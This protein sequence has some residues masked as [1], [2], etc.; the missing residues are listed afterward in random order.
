MRYVLKLVMSYVG[1]HNW[2]PCP[3]KNEGAKTQIFANL[4]TPKSTL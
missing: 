1:V 4:Q 3:P 2:P